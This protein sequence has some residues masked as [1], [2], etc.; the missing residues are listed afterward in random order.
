MPPAIKYTAGIP[1]PLPAEIA[2][3]R[4]PTTPVNGEAA[5]TTKKTNDHSP[6][7]FFFN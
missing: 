2:T 7:L 1:A 4:P 6:R 5:A 3:G